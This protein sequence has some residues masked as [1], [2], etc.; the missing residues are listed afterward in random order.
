[1]IYILYKIQFFGVLRMGVILNLIKDFL[2]W[3]N[4]D[5]RKNSQND[6]FDKI[7][8]MIFFVG[9][10]FCIALFGML[11]IKTI[12]QIL[13]LYDL[14]SSY[15]ELTWLFYGAVLG[16]SFAF[17]GKSLP[18]FDKKDISAED[19][20]RSFK[21]HFKYFFY[22]VFANLFC[23]SSSH[24]SRDKS[25]SSSNRLINSFLFTSLQI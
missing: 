25:N 20:A 23:C 10:F 19:L 12:L 21:H 8:V 6:S 22:F 3:L 4:P 1:M 11:V 7:S 16:I 5:N 9:I 2:K 17:F 15:V 24:L 14:I 18:S 13:D